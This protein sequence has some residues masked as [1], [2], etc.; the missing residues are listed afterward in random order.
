VLQAPGARIV[1]VAGDGVPV[2]Q[3]NLNEAVGPMTNKK[4]KLTAMVKAAG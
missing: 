2:K 1:P 3:Q 4:I